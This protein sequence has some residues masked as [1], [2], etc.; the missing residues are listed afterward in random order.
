MGKR[1]ARDKSKTPMTGSPHSGAAE[2]RTGSPGRS[3]AGWTEG[4]RSG[5]GDAE[6]SGETRPGLQD[7]PRPTASHVARQDRARLLISLALAAVTLLVYWRLAGARFITFDD[8]QHIVENARVAGGLTLA[9]VRWALTTGY[10]SNWQPLTWIVHMIVVQLFGL[11]AGAHHLVNVLLH[12]LSAVLLFHVLLGLASGRR[13]GERALWPAALVA[14]L[15]ALHPL[16]VESVAW[17]SEL[18][19]VLSALFW[20]LT[21][22]AYGRYA[23]RPGSGRYMVVLVC[24]ALGLAAKPM[25]VT[26]PLV[27]LLLDYWP[28]GRLAPET[29]SAGTKRDRI[30]A[31]ER[32]VIEKTPLFGMAIAVSVITYAAQQSSGSVGS[33]EDLPFRFRFGNALVCSIRYLG[34][35]VWPR[36]L[37]IYY[38]HPDRMLPLWQPVL[39]ALLLG[40]ISAAA[41]FLVRRRPWFLVG[42]FWYLIALVPVIGLVQVGSQGWADR[43]TYIPLIGVFVAVAWEASAFVGRPGGSRWSVTPGAASAATAVVATAGGQAGGRVEDRRV[44]RWTACLA[45]GAALAALA[46]LSAVQAGYWS[47]SLTLYRHALDVTRE[48]PVMHSIMGTALETEGRLGEAETHFRRAME[49]RPDYVAAQRNLG[50]VLLKQHRFTESEALLRAVLLK[51][52]DDPKALDILGEALQG[53]GRPREAETFLKKAIDLQPDS[54]ETLS[55]LAGVFAAQERFAEAEELLRR[56]LRM[57]PDSVELLGNLAALMGEQ[58]RYDEAETLLR[59][60]LALDPV[61]IEVLEN[62]GMLLTLEQRKT[63]ADAVFRKVSELKQRGGGR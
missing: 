29:G 35:T 38:P 7:P 10:A 24:F 49:L 30:R 53:Q 21:I 50:A 13:G 27:L 34:M 48:N 2:A 18:K 19:D 25:L 44:L 14:A 52:P 63:E 28:L 6:R 16:H 3:D 59:Q 31:A 4:P 23:T 36:G 45:A 11:N 12:A 40:L 46:W 37:A 1:P 57:R 42:W 9:N 54:I 26:L 33:L 39:S 61:N 15:F 8:N 56:A 20:I 62:L 5:R 22:G 60:A 51:T 55:N 43:Y 17:V 41:L 32:L 58:R 47:D